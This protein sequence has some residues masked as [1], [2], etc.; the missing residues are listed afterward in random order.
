MTG[1]IS[2]LYP[3][4]LSCWWVPDLSLRWC[5]ASA[6]IDRASSCLT[7]ITGV[8]LAKGW[9]EGLLG[10]RA[11]MCVRVCVVGCVHLGWG[12]GEVGFTPLTLPFIP[13]NK[14]L[15][16]SLCDLACVNCWE[17]LCAQARKARLW[18]H[19]ILDVC[20]SVCGGWV[21]ECTGVCETVCAQ[22]VLRRQMATTVHLGTV[23]RAKWCHD[24]VKGYIWSQRSLIP[25]NKLYLSPTAINY[26]GLQN[27]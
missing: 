10:A 15:I 19:L 14:N 17:Q 24:K 2:G 23:E 11:V 18:A 13:D 26:L 3:E 25:V 16:L 12:R 8:N 4:R 1:R 7:Y 5:W 22:G 27:C 20:V 21:G 9:G 6:C